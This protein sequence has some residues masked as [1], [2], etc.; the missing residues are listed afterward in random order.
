MRFIEQMPCSVTS[1]IYISPS[2]LCVMIA[3]ALLFMLYIET[4][5]RRLLWTS[6]YLLTGFFALGAWQFAQQQEQQFIAVY[7]VKN[8]TYI[9]FV[10]GN[11]NVA[12]RDSST[13]GQPF[14]FNLKTFFINTGMAG[15]PAVILAAHH[16]LNDTTIQHLH[17]YRNFIIFENK[18]I[19]ILHDEQPAYK[20]T[21]P[22]DY[23]IVTAAAAL[24]P[25]Q[26][27]TLYQPKQVILD[28][29][30]PAFRARQWETAVSEQAVALHN[31]KQ[32]GAW[33]QKIEDT[34]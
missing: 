6:A 21:A 2:Q 32:H 12:L 19:K 20:Q 22:V 16:P 27:L 1:N 23:L 28:A 11:H 7:N 30:V 25:A 29:S 10:H 4:K 13:A 31:V 15:N 14:D 3:L 24:R 18:L 26:A 33:I 17:T 34:N 8:A 9:H 5:N